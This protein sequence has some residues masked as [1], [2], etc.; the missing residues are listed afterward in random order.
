[1]G[2]FGI[3]LGFLRMGFTHRAGRPPGAVMDGVPLRDALRPVKIP[4]QG[5]PCC[6]LGSRSSES[7]KY[8]YHKYKYPAFSD[9]SDRDK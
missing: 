5:V 9:C 7:C 8:T 3:A 6:R 4:G 2:R 1:M